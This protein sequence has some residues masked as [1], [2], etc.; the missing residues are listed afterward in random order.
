MSK[1]IQR[2][3]E[4]FRNSGAMYAR[5]VGTED[6]GGHLSRIVNPHPI[7]VD[8]AHGTKKWDVGG[9]ELVNYMIGFDALLI[10]HSHPVITS[11]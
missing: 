10:G 9:N 2:Y 6:G 8:E 3:S 1:I 7:Y 11:A 5:A 4:K